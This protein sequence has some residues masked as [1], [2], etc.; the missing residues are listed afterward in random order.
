LILASEGFI[1]AALLIMPAGSEEEEKKGTLHRIPEG[2]GLKAHNIRCW[3]TY[4]G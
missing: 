2:Y 4:L 3:S 1:L